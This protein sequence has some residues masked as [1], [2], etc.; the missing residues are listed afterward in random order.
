MNN[1]QEALASAKKK[2]LEEGYEEKQVTAEIGFASQAI[3]ANSSLQSAAPQS[4]YN[5]VCNVLRCGTTLSP[6]AK[7]AYLVPRKGQAKLDFGYRFL[8]KSVVQTG[9]VQNLYG[10]IIYQDEEFEYN[11]VDRVVVKH[12]PVYPESEA[13]QKQRK[14]KGLVST[15]VFSNGQK[16]H[17]FLPLWKADKRRNVSKSKDSSD[18]PWKNWEEEMWIKTVIKAHCNELPAYQKT[19]QY[20]KAMELIDELDRLEAEQTQQA[21]QMPTSPLVT[22]ASA[23]VVALPEGFEDLGF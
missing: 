20:N 11:E 2:L 18:A 17:F 15:A 5:A 16:Q 9:T 19:A 4:A 12:I 22:P 13:E 6:S 14:I 21:E 8:V 10:T 3:S 23:K 1:Y 7:E